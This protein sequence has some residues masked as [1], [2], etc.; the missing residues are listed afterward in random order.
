MIK[1]RL[2]A[3]QQTGTQPRMLLQGLGW[4]QNEQVEASMLLQPAHAACCR[5]R[6][7]RLLLMLSCDGGGRVQ[8][9]PDPPWSSCPSQPSPT[10]QVP[11]P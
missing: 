2:A 5:K 11:Q 6:S 8:P 7:A 10:A 3:C 4:S 9:L 1:A